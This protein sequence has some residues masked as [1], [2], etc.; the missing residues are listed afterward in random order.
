MRREEV[1]LRTWRVGGDVMEECVEICERALR[2]IRGEGTQ[3]GSD[4]RQE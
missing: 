1:I 2:D 4:E 3:N